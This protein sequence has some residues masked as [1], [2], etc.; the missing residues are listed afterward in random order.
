MRS[1]EAFLGAQERGFRE[2]Q[3]MGERLQKVRIDRR[4]RIAMVAADFEYW[5]NDTTRRGTLV[6][7]A[8]HVREGWRFQS[9][10]FSYPD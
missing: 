9:L 10:V 1:L 2:S 5:N 7:A 8:V 3:R 6:L 4:G